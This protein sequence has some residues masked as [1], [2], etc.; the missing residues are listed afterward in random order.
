MEYKIL[1]II[2][3]EIS[4]NIAGKPHPANISD[5]QNPEN[6]KRIYRIQFS[7]QPKKEY[8]EIVIDVLKLN[9]HI[10][11]RFYGNYS[12]DLIDWKSLVFIERLQI[13]LWE[14]KNLKDIGL[15]VNLKRLAISKNVKSTVSLKILKDLKKL[16]ILFTSISKDIEIIEE[17]DK[18]KFISLREIKTKNLD[19]LKSL[20]SLNELW[21]SFGSY[22][23]I[24]GIALAENLTKLSLHQLRGID[25]ETLNEVISKCS[26]L[27]AIE[28]QNLKFLTSLNFVDKLKNLNYLRLDKI[29]NIDTYQTISKSKSLNTIST[30]E[31]RPID[32]NLIHLKN[33]ENV[34]LGDSYQKSEIEMFLK[35]FNGKTLWIWGKELKGKV[36]SK[37]PF[38]LILN[39]A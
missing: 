32:R 12:E 7:R 39:N 13:D 28:L 27:N 16:E 5:L 8:F 24:D 18:L 21:I 9:P 29:K 10:D 22:E 30:T 1:C 33:V 34:L 19:F 38:E 35:E 36:Q 26:S 37:N 4:F 2:G 23:N 6:L 14:T 11:L 3:E 17:L 20:K 31:S 15:L 25:N